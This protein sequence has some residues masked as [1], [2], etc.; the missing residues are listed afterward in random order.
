VLACGE[1]LTC[2]ICSAATVAFDLLVNFRTGV[3]YVCEGHVK[4]VLDARTIAAEYVRRY[5]LV[6]LLAAVPFFAQLA[7]YG[8]VLAT[9]APPATHSLL[10]TAMRAFRL[11]R[12]VRLWKLFISRRALLGMEIF[13]VHQTGTPLIIFGATVV[14][15]FGFLVNLMACVFIFVATAETFC[16][17]WVTQLAV[18][19][20]ASSAVGAS[21][22]ACGASLDGLVLPPGR[23]IYVTALYFAT[24]TLTTVGKSTALY[25]RPSQSSTLI[26]APPLHRRLRRRRC[27]ASGRK[28]SCLCI[29]V[30]QRILH[31]HPHG[32]DGCR[33]GQARR[34]ARG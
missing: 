18:P 9:G 29:H 28:G 8:I 34:R 21:L 12:V 30:G 17:S 16:D 5:F 2:A 20:D 1:T 3:Y 26:F 24:M 31:R 27:Q 19:P 13:V 7:F 11:L 32:P 4:L 14:Y 25:G 23:D 15:W 6:D 10:V 22:D 33:V